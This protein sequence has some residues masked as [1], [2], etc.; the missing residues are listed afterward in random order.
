MRHPFAF[1]V[2]LILGGLLIATPAHADTRDTP[3]TDEAPAVVL[4]GSIA[5]IGLFVA[6]TVLAKTLSDQRHAVAKPVEPPSPLLK[7]LLPWIDHSSKS[8]RTAW[9]PRPND[10][11]STTSSWSGQ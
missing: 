4:P 2:S 10:S 8:A 5:S 1:L 9:K 11:E 6:K 7:R 3:R